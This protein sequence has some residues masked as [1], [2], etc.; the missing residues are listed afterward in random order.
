MNEGIATMYE[1]SR[2]IKIKV[3]VKGSPDVSRD[4][5]LCSGRLVSP[6]QRTN[7]P[8]SREQISPNKVSSLTNHQLYFFLFENPI[9]SSSFDFK[10]T[11]ICDLVGSMEGGPSFHRVSLFPSLRGL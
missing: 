8:W 4:R 1:T 10:P 7:G 6:H 9:R 3:Y 5:G 11:P 2:H